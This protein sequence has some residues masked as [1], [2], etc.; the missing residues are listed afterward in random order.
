LSEWKGWGRQAGKMEDVGS[1]GE[2][3]DREEREKGECEDGRW[4]CCV[5]VPGGIDAAGSLVPCF[6]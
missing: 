6:C 1:T 2:G 4:G 5:V 3:K